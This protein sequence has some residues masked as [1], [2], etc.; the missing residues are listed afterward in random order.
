[1]FAETTQSITDVES[2]INQN[3][4]AQVVDLRK[5]YADA[6][7]CATE[8]ASE[9]LKMR[10]QSLG[11]PLASF[12]N[13]LEVGGIPRQ[14]SQASRDLSASL[15]ATFASKGEAGRLDTQRATRIAMATDELAFRTLGQLPPD[16]V[17]GLGSET[18]PTETELGHRFTGQLE[19]L[20]ATAFV[21]SGDTGEPLGLVSAITSGLYGKLLSKLYMLNACASV[22]S[23]DGEEES[24]YLDSFKMFL[25]PSDA[26]ESTTDL[27]KSEATVRTNLKA[28]AQAKKHIEGGNV[29]DALS[30][31]E[32][33]LSGEC[34]AHAL[35]W[36]EE[37][38]RT[39]LVRQ[40]MRA[41]SA[42]AACL[43]ASSTSP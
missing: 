17:G 11:V 22:E 2:T 38:R 21:P 15:L 7:D 40:A 13:L 6:M 12:T 8:A 35:P 27:T 3:L 42:K 10:L 19:N 37:T 26:D 16:A 23:K 33:D 31:L 29:T 32:A 4:E 41:V 43:N 34:R 25:W 18:M 28:L 1:M 24:S 30:I 9:E 39:L 5:R 20:V 36:M 14:R